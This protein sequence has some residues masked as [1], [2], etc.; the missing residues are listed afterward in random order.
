MA[1]TPFATKAEVIQKIQESYTQQSEKIDGI[2]S[3]FQ[4]SITTADT[5]TEEGFYFPTEAGTYANAGGL[6]YDPEDEDKGYLVQFIYDGT[7]WVKNKID[8]EMLP[9]GKIEEGNTQAVSGGEVAE[10][11][12]LKSDLNFDENLFK[13]ENIVSDKYIGGSGSETEFEGT[14]FGFVD[15]DGENENITLFIPTSGGNYRRHVFVDENDDVIE[16]LNTAQN[17]YITHLIPQGSKLLKFTIDSPEKDQVVDKNLIKANYGTSLIPEKDNFYKILGKGLEA[18][19]IN[20]N[21]ETISF[22]EK[23]GNVIKETHIYNLVDPNEVHLNSTWNHGVYTD[24]DI[25]H[26]TGLIEIEDLQPLFA[27]GSNGN[28]APVR[29]W[30]E[31]DASGTTV[32]NH[33]SGDYSV[34]T[35]ENV[36]TKHLIVVFWNSVPFD[37]LCISKTNEGYKPYKDIETS[38]ILKEQQ[39]LNS[40]KSVVTKENLD[41]AFADLPI[42]N[43]IRLNISNS[44]KILYTGSS[45]IESFYAPDYKAWVN[46]LQD[47]LDWQIVPYGWSG[48]GANSIATKFQLDTPTQVANG[49]T[50]SEINPTYVFIG[51]TLNS[52][53]L[54]NNEFDTAFIESNE[55]LL[56]SAVVRTGAKPIIGTA[57]RTEFRP[58]IENSLKHLA[59][60]WGAD[61]IP[62]GTWHRSMIRTGKYVGFYGNGHPAIRTHEAYTLPLLSY[63]SQLERPKQG[64]LIFEARNQNADILDL[65][66]KD[67]LRRAEKFRSIQVGE[68]AINTEDQDMYDQLDGSYGIKK[69]NTSE[70]MKLLRKQQVVLSDKV[71]IEFIIPKVRTDEVTLFLD[72]D[73]IT[74]YYLFNTFS[75]QFES[76]SNLIITDR[77]FIEFDKIKLLCVGESITLR[78]VYADVVGGVDK[79]KQANERVMPATAGKTI[80]ESQGFDDTTVLDWNIGTNQSYNITTYF[81]DDKFNDMPVYLGES[82]DLIVLTDVV[83][84]TFALSNEDTFGYRKLRVW[85]CARLNPAIYNPDE[86]ANWVSE[87]N[88]YTDVSWYGQNKYD[89]DDLNIIVKYNGV[90]YNNQCKSVNI[91]KVGLFWNLGYVDIIMPITRDGSYELQLIRGSNHNEYQM[92]LCD[93]QVEL[94]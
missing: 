69:N 12:L 28:T 24:S 89:Y 68:M 1:N 87:N 63:F 17:D 29:A 88:P 18:S 73:N 32:R 37:G 94:L 81:G 30:R 58:W 19:S 21:S 26:A 72:A 64:I 60:K 67:S 75:Q 57:Y 92:E 10:K 27:I 8:V 84:R 50:P 36:N 45:S 59:D 9:S 78:D 62:I 91:Q 55:N 11:V 14:S 35:P 41:D 65:G 52:N 66:Y 4:G 39:I 47:F 85:T 82:K 6:V 33:T 74:N 71:L 70:Y 2:T 15:L 76:V 3:G 77:K 23:N 40:P 79:P 22:V 31:L 44:D 46:K 83:K 13:I 42:N 54:I 86:H 20:S 49:V 48:Q 80:I 61:F 25:Y 38:Y 7:A 56:R 43:N 90:S 16:V 93:V 51:Q 53:D 34:L 5:P